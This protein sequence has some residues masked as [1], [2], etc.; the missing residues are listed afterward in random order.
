MQQRQ[1][2]SAVIETYI[3]YRDLNI[4]TDTLEEENAVE[5]EHTLEDENATG[6]AV[7]IFIIMI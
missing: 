2:S 6:R 3:Y 5:A 1:S 7:H 4:V